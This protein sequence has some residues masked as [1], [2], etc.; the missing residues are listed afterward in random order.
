V[1]VEA[2]T[3]SGLSTDV[4]EVTGGELLSVPEQVAILA[5]V[6]QKEIHCIDIPV[7]SAVQRMTPQMGILAPMAEGHRAI[8]AGR[9]SRKGCHAD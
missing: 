1:I 2:L 3:A 4:F 9:S 6:L 8:T 7:E 5:D